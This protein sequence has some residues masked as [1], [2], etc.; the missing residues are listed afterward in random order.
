MKR[1]LFKSMAFLMIVTTVYAVET[2]KN[3]KADVLPISKSFR[4]F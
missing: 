4:G 3:I 2:T 1:F